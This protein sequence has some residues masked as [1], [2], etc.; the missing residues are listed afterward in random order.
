M[1]IEDIFLEFN[2]NNHEITIAEMKR[3]INPYLDK[4]LLYGAGSAG[5][6]F[7]Y[8]LREVGI[9]PVYFVDGNPQKKGSVVEGVEVI[10]ISDIINKVGSDALII[11]TINTDGK[12]YCKSFD[13]A[14][15]VGGHTGV[16]QSL[17]EAG[18]SRVIDYTYFRRCYS[19]FV[20]DKYN[21]P[22]CSDVFLMQKHINDIVKVFDYMADDLSKETFCKIVK[23]RL[24]DD[25]IDVPT[26][27]QDDQYFEYDIYKKIENETFVDCGAFNGI[28]LKTFLKNNPTG[29]NHYYAIEPDNKNYRD[30]TEYLLSLD[31][32]IKEKITVKN[33]ALYDEDTAEIM[34]Y[35]LSGPG[36]F[37]SDIGKLN[38]PSISID[39]LLDGKKATMIKMNIEGSE[40]GVLR[41]AE[42][43]IKNYAP[44]VSVAGYHKTSDL[45]EI[46]LLLK[47][48]RDDYS[49]YLRSYMNHISF[50]FY[51]VPRERR[52]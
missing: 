43:T 28:S 9:E 40:M 7:L 44:I 37:I 12:R 30:L 13:E 42:K 17:R 3:D 34:L 6:A 24:V 18:L 46:P 45:W 39:K 35:E 2:K 16:H 29:F 32:D 14:L 25:S 8:Y 36:T 26:L 19:L 38:S 51:A 4:I 11:V 31:N 50:V 47:N 10:A 22:S 1:K 15:R 27:K 52:A 33:T 5:I 49:I 20:G 41:G 48:M 21:L 23:F